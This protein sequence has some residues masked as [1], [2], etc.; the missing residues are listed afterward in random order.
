VI[1]AAATKL[2][3]GGGP[4]GGLFSAVS[5]ETAEAVV[6]RAWEQGL[7]LFDVAPLYGHG[8]AERFVGKV[9]QAKPR[10]EFV[11]S[12]KV[13]R[14]LR[15]EAADEPSA[16]AETEGLGPVFDFS[17]DGVC[18]SL[19][20]SLERL[21]L[22]RVDIVFLHDPEEHLE[23]ALTEALPQ[24]VRLRDEGVVAAIGIGTNS[25]RAAARFAKDAELD[26]MLLANRFTLL[27]RSGED[28][29]LPLCAERDVAVIAGGVFNSGLLAS[30]R[31][32]A[33]FEYAPA[34]EALR[35]RALELERICE[36]YGVP[37][38]AAAVQFPLRH[39]AVEAVLVGV[40][41]VVELDKNI[42]AFHRPLP[43]ELWEEL[44]T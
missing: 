2:G 7:R 41:S 21:G 28:E 27:D 24:L 42:A 10:E 33:T 43:A 12:T 35:R 5:A 9:L 38:A 8:R 23:Q 16:F 40:R 31:A 3:V 26:C 22:D 18:R 25:S 15:H 20:E 14:L 32:S 30:P 37:L 36:R 4:L 44:L 1:P 19:E 29:V 11:L 34:P 6:E 39:P 17:A 13:G